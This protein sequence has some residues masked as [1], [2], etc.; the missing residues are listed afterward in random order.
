LADGKKHNAIL[1]SGPDEPSNPAAGNHEKSDGIARKKK[2]SALSE[3]DIDLPH[4]TSKRQD[5]GKNHD[6]IWCHILDESNSNSTNA[7]N[8]DAAAKLE[9]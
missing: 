1:T 2:R 9:Y 4:H 7:S 3:I 5:D 8:I 6:N